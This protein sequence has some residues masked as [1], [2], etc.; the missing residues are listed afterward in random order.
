MNTM[1]TEKQIEI[2]TAPPE[3]AKYTHAS[4]WVSEAI[5]LKREINKIEKTGA[6]VLQ[7]NGSRS[8]VPRSYRSPD[9]CHAPFWIYDGETIRAVDGKLEARPRGRSIPQVYIVAGN[10]VP[11][12]FKCFKRDTV[13]GTLIIR[14][15]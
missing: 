1:T 8:T 9:K 14:P 6:T 13:G 2:K 11:P 12:G 4:L 15:V 3:L 7:A 10:T 5:C